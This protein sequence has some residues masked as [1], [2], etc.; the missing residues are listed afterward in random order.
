MRQTSKRHDRRSEQSANAALLAIMLLITSGAS[1]QLQTSGGRSTAASNRDT[2]IHGVHV[3]AQDFLLCSEV[4]LE[5]EAETSSA[6]SIQGFHH[7]TPCEG[8]Q[9][10][11]DRRRR[12][13]PP[14]HLA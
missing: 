10:A 14:P 13:L 8:R 12:N 11:I 6:T 9:R 7:T 5:T 1:L 2:L 3:T 4:P